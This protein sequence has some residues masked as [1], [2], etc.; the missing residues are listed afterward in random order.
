MSDLTLRES[1]IFGNVPR[2]R[3]DPEITDPEHP[4]FVPLAER[5][6]RQQARFLVMLKANK[7]RHRAVLTRAEERAAS[8]NP[9]FPTKIAW[10]TED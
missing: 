6:P 10:A 9:R 1:L 2:S 3:P 7:P 8:G 5:T 4:A